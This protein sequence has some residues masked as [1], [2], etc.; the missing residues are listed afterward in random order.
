MGEVLLAFMVC[1]LIIAG[2]IFILVWAEVRE[3]RRIG[4]FPRWEDEIEG[5]VR[6]P[7]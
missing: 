3:A 1:A 5:D 6:P 4:D 7:Q 2:V